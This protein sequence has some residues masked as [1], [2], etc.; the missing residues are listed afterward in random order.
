M[1]QNRTQPS[2]GSAVWLLPRL[3]APIYS[4]RPYAFPSDF[5]T[6]RELHH[7]EPS[8]DVCP[9]SKPRSTIPSAKFL[10]APHSL[11]IPFLPCYPE[12][13]LVL[14]KVREVSTA[15]VHHMLASWRVVNLDLKF[16]SRN[17]PRG[18]RDITREYDSGARWG[19]HCAMTFREVIGKGY[20]RSSVTHHLLGLLRGTTA[21]SPSP[22]G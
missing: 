12:V 8:G 20:V 10:Q 5:F 3:I 6:S 21:S 13:F 14:H 9:T 18:L 22:I 4:S 15:Q 16:L 2:S 1:V 17:K 19:S 7:T 11:L